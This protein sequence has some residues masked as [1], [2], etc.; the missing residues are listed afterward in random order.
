MF[1]VDLYF[2]VFQW[3][4][5]RG[6][7]QCGVRPNPHLP[8][9]N[10]WRGMGKVGR[11]RWMGASSSCYWFWSDGSIVWV[12]GRSWIQVTW[13][14]MWLSLTSQEHPVTVTWRGWWPLQH[15]HCR[16][17]LAL[18]K[19]L[20]R[21]SPWIHSMTSIN[22]SQPYG[23][24]EGWTGRRHTGHGWRSRQSPKDFFVWHCDG[25]SQ[26]SHLSRAI[27]LLIWGEMGSFCAAWGSLGLGCYSEDFAVHGLVVGDTLGAEEGTG[28][29]GVWQ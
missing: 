19:H 6:W 20:P 21:S 16:W 13:S 8:W 27:S 5:W 29:C 23:K 2:P 4:G 14:V 12:L 26:P 11:Q 22:L 18:G 28:R 1:W 9:V 24:Q 10:E 15:W 7:L 25:W 17:C 3:Q